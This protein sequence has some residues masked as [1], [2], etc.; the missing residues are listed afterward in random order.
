MALIS[1]LFSKGLKVKHTLPPPLCIILTTA[2][3]RL[4]WKTVTGPRSPIQGWV[5]VWTLVSQDPVQNCNTMLHWFFYSLWQLRSRSTRRPNPL[6]TDSGTLRTQSSHPIK[7]S[8]NSDHLLTSPHSSKVLDC[9]NVGRW[10]SL[11]IRAYSV[12]F[13]TCAK[14]TIPGKVRWARSVLQ[15]AFGESNFKSLFKSGFQFSPSFRQILPSVY[16]TKLF[17]CVLRQ[18]DRCNWFRWL[19][20][21]DELP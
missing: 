13:S 4:G 19:L 7:N 17:R 12:A 2:L 6:G 9:K 1:Q 10:H 15:R 14:W 8:N 20:I 21:I 16:I 11:F 18:S 3:C 5:E